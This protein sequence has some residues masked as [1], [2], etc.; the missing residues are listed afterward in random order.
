MPQSTLRPGTDDAGAVKSTFTIV[1][2]SGNRL[3]AQNGSVLTARK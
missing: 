3:V 2:A 1:T